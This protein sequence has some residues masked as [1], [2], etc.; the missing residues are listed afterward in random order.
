[1]AE[2]AL[3][4]GWGD[5]VRGREKL[6]LDVF[7]ESVQYWTRLQQEGQIERFDVAILAPHGGD[8]GGFALLRGTAAQIDAVRRSE[9]W[10]QLVD[11]VQLR[12]G[13][14]GLIDAYV[15]EGVAKVMSE[16]QAAVGE[17]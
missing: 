8:L 13:G 10:R 7:G 17:L 4:I 14:L 16:Y 12:V 11:R 6:A 9:E 15:D 2:A 5:P 1:M 3:F